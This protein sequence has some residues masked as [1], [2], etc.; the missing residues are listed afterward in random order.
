M[1][2]NTRGQGMKVYKEMLVTYWGKDDYK[3]SVKILCAKKATKNTN[4]RVHCMIFNPVKWK[5]GN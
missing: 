5:G 4:E 3:K 1:L 2:S